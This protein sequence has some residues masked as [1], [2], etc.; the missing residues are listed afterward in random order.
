[1]DYIHLAKWYSLDNMAL[2]Y[3]NILKT[4]YIV[5]TYS[6]GLRNKNRKMKNI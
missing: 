3:Q 4:E 5:R 6:E 2:Y 1:M